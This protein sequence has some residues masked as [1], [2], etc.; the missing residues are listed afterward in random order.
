[1]CS[2]PQVVLR[3]FIFYEKSV[4]PLNLCSDRIFA[5]NLPQKNL[6][7]NCQVIYTFSMFVGFAA[8]D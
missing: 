2:E 3:Y 8:K 6:K 1:M 7:I 5:N 4:M